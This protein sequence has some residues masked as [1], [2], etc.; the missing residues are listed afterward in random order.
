[1]FGCSAPLTIS[2]S[3]L[4]VEFT[5]A[6][7]ESNKGFAIG[8]LSFLFL[9]CGTVGV[10][11]VG[12]EECDEGVPM[13]GDVGLLTASGDSLVTELVEASAVLEFRPSERLV[14]VL[15]YMII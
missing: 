4:L 2:F 10:G 11:G 8:K 14:I 7:T 15:K 13:G 5:C 12:V 9:F 6:K 3:V 1:M